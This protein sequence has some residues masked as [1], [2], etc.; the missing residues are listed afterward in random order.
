MI[1]NIFLSHLNDFALLDKFISP[2]TDKSS[3][4]VFCQNNGKLVT[5]DFSNNYIVSDFS[6]LDKLNQFKK[7]NYSLEIQ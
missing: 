6:T 3:L 4:F 7:I 2:S 1:V 5:F